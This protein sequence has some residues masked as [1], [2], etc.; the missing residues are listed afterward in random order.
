M[1]Y[2]VI[3]MDAVKGWGTNFEKAADEL[4]R[5]VNE[6][7]AQGWVTDFRRDACSQ[8]EANAFNGHQEGPLGLGQPDGDLVFERRNTLGQTAI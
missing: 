3:V 8:H 6:Q 4:S 1:Q 7:I 5:L 2:K